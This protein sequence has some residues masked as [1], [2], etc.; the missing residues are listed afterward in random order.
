M[1]IFSKQIKKLY[2]QI[3]V[4]KDVYFVEN[5]FIFNV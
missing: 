5:Y 4:I 1:Y 2:M 3:V